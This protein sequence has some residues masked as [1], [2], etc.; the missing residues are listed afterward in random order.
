MIGRV[1]MDDRDD[2]L[3]GEPFIALDVQ[4]GSERARELGVSIGAAE[5]SRDDGGT[6]RDVGERPAGGRRVKKRAQP[7]RGV[8]VTSRYPRES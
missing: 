6:R 8:P 4:E 5:S 3:Q 2:P 1:G 7:Q